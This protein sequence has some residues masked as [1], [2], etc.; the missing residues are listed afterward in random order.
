VQVPD[1]V[2][3]LTDIYA[4]YISLLSVD[5]RK[6]IIMRG[7]ETTERIVTQFCVGVG[8]R[9]VITSAIFVTID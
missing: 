1:L 5:K 8:V 2:I 6:V 7:N 4:D 9:D 3:V